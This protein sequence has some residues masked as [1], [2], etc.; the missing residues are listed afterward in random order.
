MLESDADPTIP[1]SEKGEKKG[2][3]SVMWFNSYLSFPLLFSFLSTLSLILYRVIVS[4]SNLYIPTCSWIYYGNM[5]LFI[6][7]YI[8]IYG[9]SKFA[10]SGL[11]DWMS[12][13]ERLTYLFRLCFTYGSS[14]VYWNPFWLQGI[15]SSSVCIH[16]LHACVYVS[17]KT[18][19]TE[20][21]SHNIVLA[22]LHL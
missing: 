6:Y 7:V 18:Q 16:A 1:A 11:L 21:T 8:Y 9:L 14:F 20:Q 3:S 15:Q 17:K 5:R 22:G 13:G 4:N 10:F 19:C 2:G 12:Y